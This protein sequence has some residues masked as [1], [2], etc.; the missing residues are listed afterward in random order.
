MSVRLSP[1]VV[2]TATSY[3]DSVVHN[4]AT[5]A[6][7]ALVKDNTVTSTHVGLNLLGA[8]DTIEAVLTGDVGKRFKPLRA[9]VRCTEQTGAGATGNS[10]IQIGTTAAGTDVMAATVMTGLVNTTTA[11][12]FV[13]NLNGLFPEIL[14]NAHLFVRTAVV[15]GTG[16]TMVATVTIEGVQV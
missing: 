7:H 5:G 2:M 10:Q 6:T 1:T 4:T 9:V 13:V 12:V 16:T 11:S 8:L 3:N 15:D 14:G